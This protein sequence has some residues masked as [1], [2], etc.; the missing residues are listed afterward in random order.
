MGSTINIL[1]NFPTFLK[2]DSNSNNYK[3]I[4]SYGIE[5]DTIQIENDNLTEAIQLSTATNSNLE[6]IAKL[7]K[8]LRLDGENDSDLRDRIKAFWQGSI[9]GGTETSLIN[10]LKLLLNIPESNI[11]ITDISA[12]KIKIKVIIEDSTSNIAKVTSIILRS[13]AA[14][15]FIVIE[16][17][18]DLTENYQ[19]VDSYELLDTSATFIIG[20]SEIES[21]EI[22]G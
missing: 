14:G 6:D 19:I 11:T 9:G 18:F 15:T 22:L 1:N 21:E 10:M 17:D 5:L 20:E 8:L 4:N 3:L 16:F 2:K 7:F 12:N 13:K